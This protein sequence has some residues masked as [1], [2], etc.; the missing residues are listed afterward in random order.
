LP[1]RATQAMTIAR[2][3][4]TQPRRDVTGLTEPTPVKKS[5]IIGK[6]LLRSSDT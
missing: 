5:Q 4:A 3:A 6:R 1:R 2:G